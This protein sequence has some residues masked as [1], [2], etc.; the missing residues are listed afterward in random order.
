M[1]R[2]VSINSLYH[3]MLDHYR[4]Y[5]HRDPSSLQFWGVERVSPSMRG[6][7]GSETSPGVRQNGYMYYILA[8]EGLNI[9]LDLN[10]YISDY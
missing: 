7:I 5:H 1:Y 2:I 3:S 4:C 8:S 9:E 6:P 10:C